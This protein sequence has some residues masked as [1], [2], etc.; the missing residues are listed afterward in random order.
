[1]AHLVGELERELV[2]DFAILSVQQAGLEAFGIPVGTF[3]AS[4][5]GALSAAPGDRNADLRVRVERW[6]SRPGDVADDWQD[7]DELPW[8]PVSGGGLLTVSG[9]D[10]PTGGDLAIEDIG[11]ARVQ[12]LARGRHQYAGRAVEHFEPEQ[13][14]FR[15]WPDTDRRDMLAGPPRRLAGPLP[16]LAERNPWVAAVHGWRV[17]GWSPRLSVLA[18]FREIETAVRLL[19]HPFE[20]DDLTAFLRVRQLDWTSPVNGSVPMTSDDRTINPGPFDLLDA[21]G[22]A[23]MPQ[24]ATFADAFTCLVR[25]G[26]L[27]R[28][29]TPSGE[30]W[31]PNPTPGPVPPVLELSERALR[32]RE[33]RAVPHVDL[34][35]L[36]ADLRTLVCWP[37]AYPVTPLAV[38]VRWS[39]PVEHVV[40]AFRVGALVGAWAA[41][42]DPREIGADTPVTLPATTGTA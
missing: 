15:F 25:L 35:Y 5:P 3:A 4:E 37:P 26:L 6:D 27:A 34:R 24:V 12:V 16:S 39:V 18:A 2:T 31:V 21:L 40:D 30:R 33:V 20:R 36:D 10:P 19:G 14:L 11:P 7:C 38:A 29:D 13:W 23:G 42:V 8:A 28:C 32:E 22:A 9:F 17:A 1:M 41:G